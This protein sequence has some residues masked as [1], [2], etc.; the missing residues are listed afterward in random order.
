MTIRAKDDLG[1]PR[2]VSQLTGRE[3]GLAPAE[4]VLE[5]RR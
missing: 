4:F 5:S 2:E 1:P 3:G